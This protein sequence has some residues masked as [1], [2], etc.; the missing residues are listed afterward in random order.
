MQAARQLGLSRSGLRYRMQRYSLE[1]PR[2]RG[3]ARHASPPQ[4]DSP[5]VTR[6]QG[7]TLDGTRPV[8]ASGWKEMLVA[9][10]AIDLTF[11]Q[12]PGAEAA[13]YEPWTLTSR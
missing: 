8:P 7:D 3:A 5:P 2:P 6:A 10:L 13:D 12:R 9:L 1:S 4:T 11:L